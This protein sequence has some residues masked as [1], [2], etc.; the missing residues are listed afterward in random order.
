M[1]LG[2]VVFDGGSGAQLVAMVAVMASALLLPVGALLVVSGGGRRGVGVALMVPFVVALL[3]YLQ[4]SS[5]NATA[6]KETSDAAQARRDAYIDGLGFTVH[7]PSDATRDSVR[8]DPAASPPEVRVVVPVEG[9]QYGREVVEAMVSPNWFATDAWLS[10]PACDPLSP[11]GLSTWMALDGCEVVG[12]LNDGTPVAVVPTNL[13]DV[14]VV[15]SHRGSTLLVMVLDQ[16][17]SPG[18]SIAALDTLGP[19]DLHSLS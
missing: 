4:T 10:A 15:V 18:A 6:F 1:I 14:E 19:I 11:I 17:V 9:T 13:P 12:Q 5:D 8:V 16:G 7:A 2:G 3:A